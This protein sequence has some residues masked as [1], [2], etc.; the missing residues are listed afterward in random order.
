MTSTHFAIKDVN[1]VIVPKSEILIEPGYAGPSHLTN[2]SVNCQIEDC[3]S[4]NVDHK[5][6]GDF[7]F[8]LK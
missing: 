8:F 1:L 2:V 6:M 7:R 3:G 5:I 4:M